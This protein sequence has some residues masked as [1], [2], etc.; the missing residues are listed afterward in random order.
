MKKGFTLLELIV[1][2]IVIGILAMI[3]LPRFIR[4]A[5]KARSSEGRT[6]LDSLRA[7]Q[8]R[9]YAEH[10]KYGSAIGDLDLTTSTPQYFGAITPTTGG[11]I[12]VETCVIGTIT[13]GGASNFYTL[14]IVGNGAITC[15]NGAGCATFSCVDAGY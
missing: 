15:A 3:A 6:L 5:E 10:D 4:V 7:A 9:Y 8:F 2:V 14:S 11:N 13:R 1:V 12:A